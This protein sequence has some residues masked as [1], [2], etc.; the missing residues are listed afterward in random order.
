[1][2]TSIKLADEL[3][4][5]VQ[6]LA[7]QR[8][9]SPHYLMREAIQRYVEQEEARD[10]FL[11]EARESLRH[12]EETGLHVTGEEMREWLSRWGTAQEGPAPECHT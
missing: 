6:K 4:Q 2:A 10:S 1:M 9:R 8:D 7:A 12:Y 5:R 3:K 11:R